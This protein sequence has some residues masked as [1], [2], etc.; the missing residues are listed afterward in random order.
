MTATIADVVRIRCVADIDGTPRRAD[1]ALPA[2]LPLAE[3]LP[4]L[5]QLLH[6]DAEPGIR[7]TLLTER[8][9]ALPLSDTALEAGLKPGQR[10]TLTQSVFTP[11]P[12]HIT[13]AAA[14]LSADK[15]LIASAKSDLWVGASIALLS[16][17]AVSAWWLL[18]APVSALFAALIA[19][20][21]ALVCAVFAAA[22]HYFRS[23]SSVFTN[24]VVLQTIAFSAVAAVLFVDAQWQWQLAAAGA[25]TTAF[26]LAATVLLPAARRVSCALATFAGP[27]IAVALLS[28]AGLSLVSAAAALLAV[29]LLGLVLTPSAAVSFSGIHIPEVP[30]AGEPLDSTDRRQQPEVVVQVAA[31]AA[32]LFDGLITGWML[33]I[34]ATAV[35]IAL[36]RSSWW[37]LALLLTAAVACA[38]Q[39]RGQARMLPGFSLA[40]G[41]TALAAGACYIALHLGAWWLAIP[42]L[43]L[44]LAAMPMSVGVQLWRTPSPAARRTLELVEAASLGVAI[45]LA[46]VVSGLVEFIR[47]LG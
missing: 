9:T 35:A 10:I 46:I 8:G 47:G 11:P 38:V 45:P 5:V 6:P 27:A 32:A 15:E 34:T 1:I 14:L 29:A 30:A 25:T 20:G 23:I 13:D 39:S 40:F 17:V 43:L 33:V 42:V 21:M 12:A 41:A 36:G 24:V 26:A 19:T 28:Q 2:Q 3:L 18:A 37:T 7:W 4:D 16:T 22:A 44:L 31:R